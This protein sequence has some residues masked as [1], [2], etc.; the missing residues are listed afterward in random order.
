[1]P[2]DY[3]H[4]RPWQRVRYRVLAGQ[5]QFCY[6]CQGKLG[7]IRYDV[8]WPNPLSAVVDHVIPITMFAHLPD[9]QRRAAVMNIDNLKPA[10][11]V[12]NERK[13]DRMPEVEL[14][15]NPGQEW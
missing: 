7:S 2:N 15:C 6:L 1:M 10:H 14:E 8:K 3:R 4:G 9:S 5:P 13:Q 11:K 12:C